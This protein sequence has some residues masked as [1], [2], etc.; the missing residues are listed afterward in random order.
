MIFKDVS[1]LEP[2]NLLIFS[3]EN[4]IFYKFA[5][6]ND[7]TKIIEN[8]SKNLPQ[9]LQKSIQNRQKSVQIKQKIQ[10]GLRCAQKYEKLA[11]KSEK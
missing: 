9:T 10:G 11:N 7:N 2:L 3:W 5:I 8:S 4:A 1:W 6:F